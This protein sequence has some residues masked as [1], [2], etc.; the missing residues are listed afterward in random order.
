MIGHPTLNSNSASGISHISSACQR[1]R[2]IINDLARHLRERYPGAV[3]TVRDGE[4]I[5]L[6]YARLINAP[7]ATICNPST[8]CLWPTLASQRGWLPNTKL[9]PGAPTATKVPVYFQELPHC[10]TRP[11]GL[12]L[13][14]SLSAATKSPL[15]RARLKVLPNAEMIPDEPKFLSYAHIQQFGMN[16]GEIA[17]KLAHSAR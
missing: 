15:L 17:N 3:V 12:R 2:R 9:F 10:T 6:T 14:I 16:W 5:A 7:I 8:F 1:M 11:H 13:S 4:P